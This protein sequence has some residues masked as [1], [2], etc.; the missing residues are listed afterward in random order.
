MR[1][2]RTVRVSR[3]EGAAPYIYGGHVTC[4]IYER[5]TRAQNWERLKR[6]KIVPGDRDK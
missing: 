3:K 1:P 2:S 6:L 4:V 5:V